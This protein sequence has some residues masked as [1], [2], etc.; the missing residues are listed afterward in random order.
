MTKYHITEKN[1]TDV[2]LKFQTCNR[3]PPKER[4]VH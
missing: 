3:K 4:R 2:F 1:V